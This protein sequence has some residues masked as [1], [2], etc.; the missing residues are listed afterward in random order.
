M[1]GIAKS[2]GGQL[3]E[4]VY[5]D[6]D[7]RTKIAMGEILNIYILADNRHGSQQIE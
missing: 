1:K 2:K 6:N 5:N 7:G 4:C 3:S